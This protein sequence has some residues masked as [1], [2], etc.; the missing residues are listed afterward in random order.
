[1]E[2]WREESWLFAG[3][4]T[5]TLLRLT[6]R[7]DV[8]ASEGRLFV[9]YLPPQDG[10]VVKGAFVCRFGLRNMRVV[11]AGNKALQ[12]AVITT[13]WST[14]MTPSIPMSRSPAIRRHIHFGE[15][16]TQ[17]VIELPPG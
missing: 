11:R 12:R 14:W 4:G 8:P 10:A 6:T 16:E 13:C 2:N 7:K 17:A 9:H 5:P 15:G 3:A 1:M